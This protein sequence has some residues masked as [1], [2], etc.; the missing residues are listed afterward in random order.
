M[1]FNSVDFLIFF[2]ITLT[3]YFLIVPKYRYLLLLAVSYYFYMQWNPKYIVLL[4]VSTAVTY[5]GGLFLEN[6]K[7]K[8][9]RKICLISGLMINLIILGYFKYGNMV[10]EYLNRILQFTGRQLPWDYNIVLPDGISFFTLQALGY[11]I[12]VYR[13]DTRAE[14]NFL[15]Y[16]LFISFFPQL[17]AGPIERSKNLLKQLAVPKPFSYD[18]LRRGLLIMVYGFFL[19]VVIADRIAIFV[20][21]VYNGPVMYPGAYIA[22]ATVGFAIQIYCDFYGYS[23]IA[24]G[25]ALTMGIELMENFNAPY[26]SKSIQ[27]FWRRWHISLSTWFRDY[28]YIPLGGNRKGTVRKYIN[29]MIVFSISGLWHGASM[30]FV[31]WGVL[32]GLFQIAGSCFSFLCQKYGVKWH[33]TG[34][35][36]ILR[37]LLTF[38]L[39]CF[40]WIFFRAGRLSTAKLIFSQL[41][42]A[43][44]A[45]VLINGSLFGLGVDQHFFRVLVVSILLM[46]IVDYMKY[47]DKNVVDLFFAQHLWFRVL[48][49]AALTL[50]VIAYGCYGSTFDVQQ[51]IYFQF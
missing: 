44:N 10:M 20:N 43:D 22:A 31:L 1:L 14:H 5:A 50:F 16:A 8:G 25:A 6:V 28:L 19:K 51:F 4:F 37:M 38:A 2:P 36:D 13:G 27:E 21:A 18:R 34:T 41:F 33:R 30:A 17:V 12:D 26:Y 42:G 48:A 24:K 45:F 29:L 15:K 35:D 47:K 9:K 7:E 49:A 40:A 32:H 39:V 11:L 23:T 46:G 3:L